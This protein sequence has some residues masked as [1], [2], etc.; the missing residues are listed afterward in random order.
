[1]CVNRSLKCAYRGASFFAPLSGPDGLWLVS[2]GPSTN[3]AESSLPTSEGAV[4]PPQPT[5]NKSVTP[6]REKKEPA[7]F[8]VTG[9]LQ[10]SIVTITEECT[11][12]QKHSSKNGT[13][14]HHV[15]PNM[16]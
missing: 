13:S 6:G 9:W 12:L 10:S 8:E 1:M 3:G 14:K 11:S 16:T 7:E 15:F 2:W 4:W 5:A